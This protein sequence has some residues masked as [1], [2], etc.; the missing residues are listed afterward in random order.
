MIALY[1]EMF[2]VFAMI[3][4]FFFGGGYGILPF[5]QGEVIGRGWM[6]AQEFINILAVSES[7]PGPLGINV[8]TYVGFK[9]GGIP[10]AAFSTIG[11]M[12]PAFF[13]ILLVTRAL[14]T[15]KGGKGGEI[16]G[17]WCNREQR[18]H[19]KARARIDAK[20]AGGGKR[21]IR[22]VLQKAARKGKP[23]SGKKSAQKAG[24]TD[25]AQDHG[26]NAVALPLKKPSQQFC[27]RERGAAKA[28]GQQG[29]QQKCCPGY[30]K[31]NRK[32]QIFFHGAPSAKPASTS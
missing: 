26:G 5:I 11:L 10:G 1:V 24:Q 32:R 31:Q 22:G 18:D 17:V 20:H 23:C 21:V 16:K 9:M 14:R 27:K 29:R 2:F 8:A 30:G 13:L 3:G 4:L 25:R 15:E 6:T 28:K 19:K 7:T 12:M